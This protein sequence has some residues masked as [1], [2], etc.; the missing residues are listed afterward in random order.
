MIA[1]DR[2]RKVVA[3]A[4]VRVHR[5]TGLDDRVLW[6]LGP[7]RVRYEDAAIDVALAAGTEFDALAV[8]PRCASRDVRRRAGCS[9]R[10]SP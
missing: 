2:Q 1:V 4:G 8:S 9:S 7:P 10:W 5:M 3:P 6:N